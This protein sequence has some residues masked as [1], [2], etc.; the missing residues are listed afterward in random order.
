MP[1][2]NGGYFMAIDASA[3]GNLAVVALARVGEQLEKEEDAK[4]E[5]NTG[6]EID[7]PAV[8]CWLTA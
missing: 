6:K 2:A 5:Y 3:L 4:D 7:H 8:E 1:V